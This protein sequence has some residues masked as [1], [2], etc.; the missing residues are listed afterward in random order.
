MDKEEFERLSMEYFDKLEN[1]FVENPKLE[2]ELD[3]IKKRLNDI[4]ETEVNLT[5]IF[6]FLLDGDVDQMTDDEYKEHMERVADTFKNVNL[7][8]EEEYDDEDEYMDDDDY[9]DEISQLKYNKNISVEEFMKELSSENKSYNICFDPVYLDNKGI[10]KISKLLLTTIDNNV[11][12]VPKG[13][14]L[15]EEGK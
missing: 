9:D 12:I 3:D 7:I 8:D 15:W 13:E 10:S 6:P 5:F 1:K 2:A 4:F 14:K 11:I